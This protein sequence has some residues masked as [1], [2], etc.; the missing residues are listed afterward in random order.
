MAVAKINIHMKSSFPNR[1]KRQF[2]NRCSNA[3]T[4]FGDHVL[5]KRSS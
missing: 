3:N 1:V 5:E 4:K 2:N